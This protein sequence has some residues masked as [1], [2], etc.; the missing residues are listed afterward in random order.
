MLSSFNKYN[1]YKPMI[2]IIINIHFKYI[3]KIDEE[4]ITE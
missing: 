4:N 3:N 1:R 2:H